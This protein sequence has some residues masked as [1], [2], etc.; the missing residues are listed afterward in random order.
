MAGE[1][2]TQFR[3]ALYPGTGVEN[4][5]RR[6]EEAVSAATAAD[7][8]LAFRIVG[9]P[10]AP[11]EPPPPPPAVAF[12]MRAT[13]VPAPGSVRVDWSGAVGPVRFEVLDAHGRRVD[14]GEG[15]AA[16]NWMWNGTDRNG[17]AVA[18]GIYFVHARDSK[19]GQV[20][21]Q[22]VLVR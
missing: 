14:E 10:I 5:K 17:Q 20:V 22:V 18:S 3:L 9:R 2:V 7:Q 6:V 12:S 21:R 15:G 11:P 13:P 19:G 8:V 4:L 1:S 16:G